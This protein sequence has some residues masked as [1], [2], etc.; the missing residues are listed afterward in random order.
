MTGL[1]AIL[2]IVLI[3]VIVVQIGRLSE[4]AAKIRG[5]EEVEERA[6]NKTAVYLLL[7]LV[8]FL[9]FCLEDAL[10]SSIDAELCSRAAA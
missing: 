1:L 2:I 9:A 6:N 5:E 3:A 8:A 10:S 7:F 4:I